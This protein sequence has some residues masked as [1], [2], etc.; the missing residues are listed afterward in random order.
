LWFCAAGVNV[1][2]G[3][4]SVKCVKDVLGGN[5]A[6]ISRLET[7]ALCKAAVKAVRIDKGRELMRLRSVIL[8]P[9]E[10]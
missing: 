4:E 2:D 7:K 9:V 1:R 8:R 10:K 6:D 5:K 3:R